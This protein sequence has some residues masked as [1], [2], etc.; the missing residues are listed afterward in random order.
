MFNILRLFTVAIACLIG[1]SQAI[2]LC[3]GGIQNLPRYVGETDKSARGIFSRAWKFEIPA[4][5]RHSFFDRCNC[6][7]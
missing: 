6:N 7:T 4:G 2:A 3:P 1:W 5:L